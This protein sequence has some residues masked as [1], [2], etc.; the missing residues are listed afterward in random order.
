MDLQKKYFPY[1]MISYEKVMMGRSDD[2]SHRELFL[3]W[4]NSREIMVSHPGT[5]LGPRRALSVNE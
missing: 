4:E 1:I 3:G 2:G 5:G